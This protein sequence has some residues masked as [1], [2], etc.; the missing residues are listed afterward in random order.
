MTSMDEDE[1]D[2]DNDGIT[3]NYHAS[4]TKLNELHHSDCSLSA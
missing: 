3:A 4:Q 1:E 2:F